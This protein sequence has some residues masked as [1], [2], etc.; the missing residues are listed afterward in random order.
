M[1]RHRRRKQRLTGGLF[2]A[3][4][5]EAGREQSTAFPLR[6]AAGSLHEIW[7]TR[8]EVSF[9]RDWLQGRT[10]FAFFACR[11][12]ATTNFGVP[13]SRSL[14]T[15]DSK[16]PVVRVVGGT[17]GTRAVQIFPRPFREASG[18]KPMIG[19]S[20]CRQAIFT[21]W[22]C[23]CSYARG[24]RDGEPSA[25]ARI[26]PAPTASPEGSHAKTWKP[27]GALPRHHR[28]REESAEYAIRHQWKR[29]GRFE[30]QSR[31]NVLARWSETR[32]HRASTTA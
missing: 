6:T 21:V 18:E 1:Q 27:A 12:G 30:F 4:L 10:P 25:D 26:L 9:R 8:M 24:M 16:G 29:R 19:P 23:A 14:R 7:G 13:E 22:A 11:S 17:K 3:P 15:Y 5:G 32:I 2:M 20:S 31:G 28:R